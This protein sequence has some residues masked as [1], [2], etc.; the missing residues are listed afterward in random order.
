MTVNRDP[1]RPSVDTSQG[2][3]RGGGPV[4]RDLDSRDQCRVARTWR[5]QRGCV[6]A[7]L[8][9]ATQPR[10][11]SVDARTRV[12]KECTTGSGVTSTPSQRERQRDGGLAGRWGAHQGDSSLFISF[13]LF[14]RLFR[15]I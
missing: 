1:A 11:L 4:R 6:C 5:V 9:G 12:G 13:L 10:E 14:F 15:K 2:F 8:E 7:R 3:T